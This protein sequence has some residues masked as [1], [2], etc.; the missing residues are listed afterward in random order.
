MKHPLISTLVIVPL[1]LGFAS[2]KNADAALIA[3]SDRDEFNSD[4]EA[5][6]GSIKE[7]SFEDYAPG[8]EFTMQ[9]PPEHFWIASWPAG[10]PPLM[11]ANDFDTTDGNNYLGVNDS[12]NYNS[13]IAGIDVLNIYSNQQ[14][15]F[16]Q[17]M[18]G[19]GMDFITSDPILDGDIKLQLL[20]SG[21]GFSYVDISTVDEMRLEDGGYSYF[22]GVISTDRPLYQAG[23]RFDPAATGSFLFNIDHITASYT[24]PEPDEFLL[25][26]SALSLLFWNGRMIQRKS[27]NCR[28]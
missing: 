19:I 9:S 7:Q 25:L 4:L 1:I 18:Y 6:E 23:V 21:I 5:T 2:P 14:G 12:E 24:V 22:L 8:T 11:V 10:K 13:M 16:D 20:F 26:A 3:Y 17:Y 28:S 15:V 27:L